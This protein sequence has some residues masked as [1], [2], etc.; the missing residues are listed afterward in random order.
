M[1]VCRCCLF[2]SSCCSASVWFPFTNGVLPVLFKTQRYYRV[3]SPPP[4]LH[5]ALFLWRALSHQCVKYVV[6]R[7]HKHTGSLFLADCGYHVVNGQKVF[8]HLQSCYFTD[9]H[10]EFSSGRG[11]GQEVGGGV[12][13]G[14]SRAAGKCLGDRTEARSWMPERTIPQHTRLQWIMGCYRLQNFSN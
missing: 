8:G 5:T 14:Q 4:P 9:P 11:W 7:A 2:F 12:T 6:K 3:P 10:S 13:S 1:S